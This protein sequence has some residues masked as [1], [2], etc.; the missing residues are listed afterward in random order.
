MWILLLGKVIVLAPLPAIFFYSRGVRDFNHDGILD[1]AVANG[2]DPPN[3]GNSISVL[4]GKG[5]GT[6]QAAQTYAAGF[7]PSSVAAGD[8][9]HDGNLDLAVASQWGVSI[10]LGDGTGAFQLVQSYTAGI[11]GSVVVADLNG[12]GYPDLVA[13]QLTRSGLRPPHDVSVLLNA[14]DWGDGN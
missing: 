14:T 10:L 11:A 8:F 6:F 4:L 5:D 3:P 9:N 13:A 7:L 2:G 12:D 1:L